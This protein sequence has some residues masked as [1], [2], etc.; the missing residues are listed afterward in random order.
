M[1]FTRRSGRQAIGSR[2]AHSAD[3][4]A[5]RTPAAPT[6]SGC[7]CTGRVPALYGCWTPLTRALVLISNSRT[8]QTLNSVD[9]A[10]SNVD[11]VKARTATPTRALSPSSCRATQ[12]VRV[13][14]KATRLRSNV[15]AV[16]VLDLEKRLVLIDKHSV[17]AH[18]DAGVLQSM[19]DIGDSHGSATLAATG[20]QSRHACLRRHLGRLRGKRARRR[21]S[22]RPALHP[23]LR[24]SY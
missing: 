12:H 13:H 19:V 1:C 9:G 15:S 23:Q 24:H 14:E 16:S 21:R 8:K 22:T 17:R 6:D 2:T 18:Q 7:V 3:V 11:L 5:D 4:S 20:R 10:G